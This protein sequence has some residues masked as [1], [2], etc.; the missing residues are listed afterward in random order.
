MKNRKFDPETKV[1]IVLEGLK[2]DITVAELCRKYKISE[3]IYY[4]WRDKFLEGGRKAFLC[5]EKDREKE[6]EKRIAELEKIIGRQT[7][8]IE[9][10]KKTFQITK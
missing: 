7:I 5:S 1:A 3:T 10:L 9:I 4:R 6:L 8:Q 2:G